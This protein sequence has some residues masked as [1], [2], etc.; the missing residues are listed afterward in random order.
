MKKLRTRMF[1]F[2]LLPVLA[3]ILAM[4]AYVSYK[5]HDM[6]MADAERI[7]LTQGEALAQDLGLELERSL[8]AVQTISYSFQGLISE[9]FTPSRD[10]AHVM[11]KQLLES[12]H[13]V[14]SAWMFWEPNAFDGKD[15]EY[16][17]TYGHDHTGRFIPVWSKDDA[18]NYHLEPMVGYDV[19]GELHD[20]LN[21]VLQSGKNVLFEPLHYELNGENVLVTSVVAPVVIKGKT[22]G[23]TGVD[24]SLEQLDQMISQFSFY[25][26][27]FAGL[28][29]NQGNVLSHQNTELIGTNYFESTAMKDREDNQEVQEAVRT[30][31]PVIIEGFSNALQQNVYRLFTPIHIEGVD[32]PWSA[33]L[34][35]PIDEVTK[36][37][38]EL[39]NI[40][41]I[42]CFVVVVILIAI[43]L[44]VTRN[45]LNPILAMV[46]Y[47]QQLAMGDFTRLLPEK[48]RNRKDELGQLAKSF[49]SITENMRD[50]LRQV[51]ESTQT[52]LQSANSMD[53]VA[54]QAA[55]SAQEVA[56]SMEEVATSA[57]NQMQSAEESAKSMEEM[58]QG[59]QRV[60]Q[61]ASTVV[62][63][64]SE[65]NRKV[66][67]GELTVQNA[68]KQMDRIQQETQETRVKVEHLQENAANIGNIVN[69]IT[70]ISEQTN[71]L[72]LNAA[73]ESARAGEAGM[74]FA[75]VAEEV[76]KLANETKDSA[77]DIQQLVEAIQKDTAEVTQLIHENQMEVNQG[78]ERIEEVGRVFAELIQYIQQVVHEIE[79]LS[80]ISQEMSAV[81]EEITAAS[82]E[83]ASSAEV[84]SGHTQQVAA[85]ASDQLASMEEMKKTAATL[86]RMADELDKLL[87][88]FRT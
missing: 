53:E 38:S 32:T 29:S 20:Y 68:V 59:V 82:E 16:A 72:A 37:V 87:K 19:A 22:V 75:V 83:I 40:I 15:E 61:A 58:S 86:Q 36:E 24:V 26:T 28:I 5:V 31:Q 71:L 64:A 48:Y 39:M 43:I 10:E 56:T 49:T 69:I 47:G 74:G 35:A 27:G 79:E 66:N 65:M 45:L 21:Y 81:T 7:L 1:V 34:A 51:Q 78:I 46:E 44:L 13:N 54:K 80:A 52:V 9:G 23:M 6:V 8:K 3:F 57:E 67:D 77:T 76:R 11:L 41:F 55:Q 60:A 42:S 4:V 25:D 14:I 12:N 85:L 84:A 18:G 30:G 50:L 2:F 73:I 33:F 63:M 88:Q 62:D 17:N 70:E